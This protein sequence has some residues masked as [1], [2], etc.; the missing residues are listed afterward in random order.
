MIELNNILSTAGAVPNA[1]FGGITDH[2]EIEQDGTLVC[3][4]DSTLWDDLVSSLIA[5]R[6]ESTVGTLQ[7]NYDENSITMS[8]NGSISNS[9]DRLIVNFQK[10][11]GAKTD[12]LF[13]L[14]IHWE[15]VSTND[16]QF[17]IQY[18]IQSNGESKTTA[19]T[20]VVTNSSAGNKFTY[21]SGT[22]NQI[23]EISEIDWSGATIS[24]TLQV[25]LVRTDSTTGDIEATFVDGHVERDGFGS[26][27]EYI[28]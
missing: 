4:G 8:P 5:R 11:H 21:T 13:H 14:H 9:A 12:S 26:R 19:W 22:L 16:V 17:T 10:P 2:I 23:T 27:Q 28:K 15:Q 7:Y 18:R 24:S 6:L 3:K 20:E 1:K 25:R